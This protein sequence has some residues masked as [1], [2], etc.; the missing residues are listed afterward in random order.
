LGG[1]ALAV[2]LFVG[3][4]LVDLR[5]VEL[6]DFG[7][8]VGLVE[9]TDFADFVDLTEVAEADEALRKVGPASGATSFL[10]GTTFLVVASGS[11]NQIKI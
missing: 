7:I 5:D 6:S 4:L 8:V 2:V 11:E 10:A 3:V 9:E 1:L